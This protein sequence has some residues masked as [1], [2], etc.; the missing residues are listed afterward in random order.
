MPI[1]LASDKFFFFSLA[2]S[3]VG[4]HSVIPK[5]VTPSRIRDNFKEI[6]LLPEE[7]QKVSLLGKDR[8]R[9][10]TPYAANKPRWNINIFGEPDEQPADHK[11]IV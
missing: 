6:E 11:V 3:Q 2:W 8:R 7:V 5:S 10:N 4:G 1:A 9:Y